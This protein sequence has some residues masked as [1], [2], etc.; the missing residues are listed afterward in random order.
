MAVEPLATVADLAT[1]G[2]DDS[3]RDLAEALLASVS[4]EV[5]D[6]AGCPIVKT[7]STATF[8][9]EASRRIELP[10]RPVRSVSDVSLNGES[11]TAGTDY[12][13]RG[14]C[15]WRTD[16]RAWHRY[17]DIPGELEVTFEH[18]YDQV[19]E[20]IV[21]MVCMYVAAGIAAS[22]DQFEGH[23]GLQYRG[24]DDY[25]EGYLA[26]SDE[27]VDEASLTDRT[28]ADLAARFGVRSGPSVIGSVR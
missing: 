3:N 1:Y 16:G 9:T 25:R 18:G 22:K 2:I 17:G 12:V 13:V 7:V 14:D 28:K 4:D 20:D 26:G 19:P 21:R 15:L 8:S 6:A 23:R 5:R 27:V 10:A 11:L 24:V